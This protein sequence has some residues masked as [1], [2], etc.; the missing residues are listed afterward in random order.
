MKTFK[1]SIYLLF[2]LPLFISCD[3]DGLL[4]LEQDKSVVI[5]E[6]DQSTVKIIK[7]GSVVDIP[8]VNLQLFGRSATEDITIQYDVDETKTT[9]TEG[10]H[11]TIGQKQLSL[12][13]GAAFIQVPIEYD[14]EAIT[15]TEPLDIVLNISSIQGDVRNSSASTTITI[16]PRLLN[17]EYWSG[18]YTFLADGWSREASMT[19]L[20]NGED[21]I[22]YNFWGNGLEMVGKVVETDA[23]SIKFVVPAGTKLDNGWDDRG[24]WLLDNDLIGVFDTEN[25]LIDFIQFDYICEDGSTGSFPWCEE[26]CQLVQN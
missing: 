22:M 25:R 23:S 4:E 9:A 26:T 3:V 16:K 1:K 18:A 5:W 14:P 13:A 21:M 17:L 2:I 15:S 8:T 12:E 7:E 20:S 19:A 11:F 6:K 10:L 24:A